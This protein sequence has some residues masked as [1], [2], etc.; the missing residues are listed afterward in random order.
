MQ[1]IEQRQTTPS[2]TQASADQGRHLRALSA[3]HGISRVLRRLPHELEP[4][5]R[6]ALA[7]AIECLSDEMLEQGC[8]A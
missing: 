6:Q 7:E 1:D 2:T 3:I 8:C 4:S 5:E